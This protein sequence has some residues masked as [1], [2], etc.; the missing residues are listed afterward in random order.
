MGLQVE[1]QLRLKL[2]ALLNAGSSD[3]IALLKST[4]EAL[5]VVAFGLDWAPGDRVIIPD[6]EFPSNRIVWE[7]LARFGVE[8]I[9][10]DLCSAS[11]PEEALIQA[12]DP[13]TRL[14]SVS[15]VQYATGLALDL[16]VLGAA[17]RDHGTLF[18][19]DAIQS[20]GAKPFDVQ[21][22]RADFVAADGHKWMLGPEGLAVFYC[23]AE[24][25]E[26]LR[27]NQF[28]WHMVEAMGDFDRREWSPA[29][30][31]R[32]FECGS[33][34]MLGIH[35]LEASLG[36][37]LD[38][39]MAQVYDVI[40]S[41]VSYLID[42]LCHEYDILSPVRVD[43]RAGIFTFAPHDRREAPARFRQ[44][45]DAGVMCAARAGGIRFSPHFYTRQE[46]LD[47]AIELCLTPV[48]GP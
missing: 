3:E 46:E 37:L 19:V 41:K 20:L 35:A 47:R 4:S 8:V 16:D 38:Q 21:A 30:S 34:N 44:L 13:K 6:Q 18:C 32:R 9:E 7:A 12:F 17:C 15:A 25:L 43:R 11:T 27:L 10:V 1:Q 29:R 14:L 23:R 45:Q 48:H 26:R 28:G 42:C 24:H 40:S 5:S 31:A 2:K 22:C 36:V 33:P 39:G